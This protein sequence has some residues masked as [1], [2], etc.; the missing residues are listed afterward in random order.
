MQHH[1]HSNRGTSTEAKAE[2][3]QSAIDTYRLRKFG[4]TNTTGFGTI[5]ERGGSTCTQP[6]QMRAV[7]GEGD[8]WRRYWQ[9]K[10]TN[11]S[12]V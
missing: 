8:I 7:D 3:K 11:N 5:V 1:T 10:E 9:H 6:Q 2:T 4:I 12:D